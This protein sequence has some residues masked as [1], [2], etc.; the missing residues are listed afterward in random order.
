MSIIS[1]RTG[2]TVPQLEN[3]VRIRGLLL[4]KLLERNMS[5][6]KDV[7]RVVNEYYKDPESVLQF[8]GIK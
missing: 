2:I 1:K 7:T 3:E 4:S 8:F 6:Y 5:H